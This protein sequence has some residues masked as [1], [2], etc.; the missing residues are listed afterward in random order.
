MPQ[1]YVDNLNKQCDITTATSV[2]TQADML[3]NGCSI[4]G[5]P[6]GIIYGFILIM[7]RYRYRM[8]FMGKW[9]Y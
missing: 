7:N 5:L 4:I 9:Y 8:Y 6:F 1:K 2:H 3:S